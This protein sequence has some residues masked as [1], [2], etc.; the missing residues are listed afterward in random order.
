[1]LNLMYLNVNMRYFHAN[2]IITK[3]N[4]NPCRERY[5]ALLDKD[6]RKHQLVSV[7]HN[8]SRDSAIDADLQEWETETLEIDMVCT[9]KKLLA[10]WI[11]LN[12]DL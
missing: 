3:Q 8:N 4:P 1:M 11:Y 6:A 7:G 5:D 2:T 9:L 12:G 10:V